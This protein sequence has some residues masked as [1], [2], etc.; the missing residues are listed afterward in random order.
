MLQGWE[1]RQGAYVHYFEALYNLPCLKK[2]DL[3]S[4]NMYRLV[5]FPGEISK[6]TQQI[7]EQFKL[8]KLK[9]GE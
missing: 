3:K 2:H 5:L 4:K 1:D 8:A 9:V 6:V 7:L